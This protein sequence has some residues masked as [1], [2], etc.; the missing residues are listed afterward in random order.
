[1]AMAERAEIADLVADLRPEEWEAPTLCEQWRVR[2]VIAHVFSYEE[3][4]TPGLIGQF[5]GGRFTRGGP[6]AVSLAA[7]ADRSPDDLVALVNG[8]QRPRGLTAG[9]GGR[10]ALTDG[11]IH[12]QDIRRQLG[13][14]LA[15]PARPTGH[16]ARVRQDR[17]GDQREETHPRASARGDR[18]GLGHR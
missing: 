2:D 15:D 8:H 10:I 1:M 7:Y 11:T 16:R 18:P 12:H 9:F 6:N 5:A 17:P 14:P 3:L 4:S 13:R